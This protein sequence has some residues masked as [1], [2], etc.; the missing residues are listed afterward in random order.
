M[1]NRIEVA[2]KDACS[3]LD[4][5]Y[6]MAEPQGTAQCTTEAIKRTETQVNNLLVNYGG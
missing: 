4:E 5:V 1:K 6:P 2:A 3:W